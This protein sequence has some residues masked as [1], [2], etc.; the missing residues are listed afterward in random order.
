MAIILPEQ[1][2]GFGIAQLPRL[3]PGGP[4]TGDALATIGDVG[5]EVAAQRRKIMDDRA[6]REARLAA[7]D[8]LDQ[9]RVA[10]ENDTNLD[11]LTTRWQADAGAVVEAAGRALPAHL[12]RDFALSMGDVVGSQTSAVRTRENALYRDQ[13]TAQLNGDMRRFAT[14]AAAA[15]TPE[16]RDAVYASAAA[17]IGA[18]QD[19]GLLSAV[20]ADQI[21]ADLPAQTE[22]ITA[23]ELVDK[24]PQAFLDGM[25]AG[26]FAF[27]PP[28]QA[29][30]FGIAAKANVAATDA[31]RAKEDA[32]LAD[33]AAKERKARA[34]DAITLLEGGLRPANLGGLMADLSG[35]PDFDRVQG[36]VDAAAVGGNFPLMTPAQQDA[37]LARIKSTAS[38][39][40]SDV[41]LY[42]RLVDMRAKTAASLAADPIAHVRD[43][44]IAPVPPVDV[45]DPASVSSRVAMAEAI[46]SDFTPGAATI[47]YFDKAE[48]AQLAATVG[49]ANV[50][51]A[52]R[53]L[54]GINQSFGPRA[55]LALAQIG[56]SDV[57]LQLAGNLVLETGD[58]TAARTLL[59]G[60]AMKAKGEGAAVSVDVQRQ[61]TAG[62]AAAFPAA[63]SARLD[64][65]TQAALAHYAASG[66]GVADPKSDEAVATL[67]ASVQAVM[68]A[69]TQNGVQ[70]GGIQPVHDVQAVLPPNMT[71]GQVEEALVYL[72][73]AAWLRASTSGA[74]PQMSSQPMLERLTQWNR[75]NLTVL[76]LGSGQYALGYRYANGTVAYMADPAQADGLFRFD[77]EKLV[78]GVSRNG[79]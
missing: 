43:R 25:A 24:D 63:D 62:F 65:L 70:Y 16:A 17:S 74:A 21:M 26:E 38:K 54:T 59:L 68:G 52:L 1:Q 58:V 42:N 6:L 51:E 60:R 34:D 47:T 31:Q 53:V 56:A 14:S 76:S 44:A 46:Y 18:A 69:R 7:M 29:A 48:A 33:A 77:L 32:L 49:G 55:P 72:D 20:E 35:T 30:K 8:G 27:L 57:T 64:T 5:V 15:P 11:G 41:G 75:E 23:L 39:N 9:A 61:V 50:D 13:A 12:R 2:T 40:P 10:Y 28:D 3:N 37:E 45:M 22:M 79:N 71:G 67:T 4:N 36:A 73:E 19:A 66:Q 78:T